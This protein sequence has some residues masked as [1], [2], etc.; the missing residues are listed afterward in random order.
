[1]PPSGLGAIP[2][3]WSV[4][5]TRSGRPAHDPAPRG[6][7]G[8]P[9]REP[10]VTVRMGEG[11]QAVID[12]RVGYAR[13]VRPMRH[14]AS[15]D[16]RRTVVPVPRSRHGW[17]HT[18]GQWTTSG[19]PGSLAR[20]LIDGERLRAAR[21][22]STCTCR[23]AGSWPSWVHRA[24]AR[25]RCCGSIAGPAAAR[26]GH[27]HGGRQAGH[28][29]RSG[30]RARVPGAPAAALADGPRQRRLSPRAR[31]A[32]ARRTDGTRA[33]ADGPRG[34]RRV[35]GGATRAAVGRHGAA[36]RRSHGR[37]RSSRGCCCSTSRSARSTR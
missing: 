13:R 17:P 9:G 35:R 19:S 37:S 11:W 30:G 29:H 7:G 4:E 12:G 25:A 16:P 22:A 18:D 10:T 33:G 20:S 3:R 23:V 1:M 28:G 26:R 21:R 8:S 31:R 36:G 34:P 27:H 2:D 5:R 14:G 24:P 32:A 15:I 6:D